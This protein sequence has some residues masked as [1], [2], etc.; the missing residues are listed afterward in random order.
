M[1]DAAAPNLQSGPAGH[2]RLSVRGRLGS[3]QVGVDANFDAPWT[4][5]FGPSGCGK[6][7]LL[8]AVAG[9]TTGLRV[10]VYRKAGADRWTALQDGDRSTPPEDRQLAY[11]PQQ[12]AL[13]PHLTVLENVAFASSIRGGTTSSRAMAADALALFDLRALARRLPRELSG[14]ERQRV[15]LARALAVPD[16][17]LVLLDEPFAG[18]DRALRDTF[19]PP[20][21]ELLLTRH[22]PVISVTHDVDEV[23]LLGADVVRLRDGQVIAQGSPNNVLAEE[24]ARMRRA[25]QPDTDAS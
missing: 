24:A 3:L 16:A 11:A 10:A 6:S 13:F 25:L 8:R 9:L 19:L 12:A 23:F 15:S 4:V 17:R 1:P 21:Q 22:T 5:L 2:H 20:M 14:G 7:T 18:L